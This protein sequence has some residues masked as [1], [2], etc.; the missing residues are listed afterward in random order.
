MLLPDQDICNVSL[1]DEEYYF[2]ATDL[3]WYINFI[4][5][6]WKAIIVFILSDSGIAWAI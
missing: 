2:F 4:N 1:E 3:I 5:Y 6:Q